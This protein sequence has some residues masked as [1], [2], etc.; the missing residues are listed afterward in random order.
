M[1]FEKGT[2][3]TQQRKDSLFNQYCWENG[4]YIPIVLLV[5]LSTQSRSKAS[6]L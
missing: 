5:Q 4:N 2:K 6:I 3:N 1:I